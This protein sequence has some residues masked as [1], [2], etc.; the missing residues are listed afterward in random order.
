[1]SRE[2]PDDAIRSVLPD[3]KIR[4]DSR[5]SLVDPDCARTPFGKQQVQRAATGAASHLPYRPQQ[6]VERTGGSGGN[7]QAPSQ[8]PARPRISPGSGGSRNLRRDRG[9]RSLGH[10]LGARGGGGG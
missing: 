10:A 4:R 5:R 3:S 8:R 2:K 6:A 1:M 7:H 9:G